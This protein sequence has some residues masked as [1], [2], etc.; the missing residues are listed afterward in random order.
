MSARDTL[1]VQ[2]SIRRALGKNPRIWIALFESFKYVSESG[3]LFREGVDEAHGATSPESLRVET[4]A[5]TQSR[6]SATH[7]P[8]AGCDGFD[9]G[10]LS[11]A[12]CD[13]LHVLL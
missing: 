9:A 10:C 11:G 7:P 2:I 4:D 12:W 5:E 13:A 6:C 1:Q 8:S 3:M